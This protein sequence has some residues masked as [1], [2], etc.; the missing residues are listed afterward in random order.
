PNS[1]LANGDTVLDVDCSVSTGLLHALSM[2]TEAILSV[3]S[4]FF[5]EP[6]SV[7]MILFFL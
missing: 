3:R 6:L 7:G 5:I 2:K 4:V 1:A